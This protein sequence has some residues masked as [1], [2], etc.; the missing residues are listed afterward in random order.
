MCQ[1]E[2]AVRLLSLGSLVPRSTWHRTFLP[3]VMSARLITLNR[4]SDPNTAN[5]IGKRIAL[6]AVHGARL[7]QVAALTEPASDIKTSPRPHPTLCSHNLTEK[8]NVEVGQG[9]EF[10]G[11]HNT[12]NGGGF[13]VRDSTKGHWV[14][15]GDSW[16]SVVRYKCPYQV[17]L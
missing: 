7:G 14:T 6:M 3:T 15:Y 5:T 2:V 9:E 13:Q 4:S 10:F 12:M 11:G 1:S 16:G 8:P 17:Y